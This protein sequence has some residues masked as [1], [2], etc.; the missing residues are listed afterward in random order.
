MDTN[1]GTFSFIEY[2]VTKNPIKAAS[3]CACRDRP[4]KKKQADAPVYAGCIR[5]LSK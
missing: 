1:W 4:A 3:F 2:S 5:L